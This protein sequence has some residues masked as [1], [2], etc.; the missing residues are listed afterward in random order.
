MQL[1]RRAG[2]GRSLR[3]RHR[4]GRRRDRRDYGRVD[5][6]DRRIGGRRPVG[7][8]LGSFGNYRN[9]RRRSFPAL[10]RNF[11]VHTQSAYGRGPIGSRSTRSIRSQPVWHRWHVSYPTIPFRSITRVGS[12]PSGI[13]IGPIIRR[14]QK[15]GKTVVFGRTGK[16]NS[17]RQLCIRGVK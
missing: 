2:P 10:G 15:I 7:W 11:L 8:D 9:R 16:S 1:V 4:R 14:I 12:K 5:S 17:A 6:L 3:R 13:V